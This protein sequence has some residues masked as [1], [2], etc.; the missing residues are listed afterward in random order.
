MSPNSW[1]SRAL[2][3]G[4]VLAVFLIVANSQLSPLISRW[5]ERTRL[6]D[7]VEV[8]E[9]R[10]EQTRAAYVAPYALDAVYRTGQPDA[11]AADLQAALNQEAA[12]AGLRQVRIRRLPAVEA[13]GGAHWVPLDF[14]ARGD[15]LAIDGFLTR[16]Q[17]REP[18][19]LIAS[20]RL[21]AQGVRRP[22]DEILL[23]WRVGVLTPPEDGA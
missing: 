16:L 1:P 19:L 14:E 20:A 4:L 6:A 5:S 17:A 2:A 22:D 21:E 7:R 3:L 8:L 9:A 23:R 13:E 12:I 18:G 11:L 15:L 10:L